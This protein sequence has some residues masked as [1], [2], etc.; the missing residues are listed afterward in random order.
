MHTRAMAIPGSRR[1]ASTASRPLRLRRIYMCVHT[2]TWLRPGT[3]SPSKKDQHHHHLR[4][5]LLPARRLA[6]SRARLAPSPRLAAVAAAADSRRGPDAAA[7]NE[8]PRAPSPRPEPCARPLPA[9]LRRPDEPAHEA[10]APAPRRRRRR[11]RRRRP[12]P[13]PSTPPVPHRAPRDVPSRRAPMS[14]DLLQRF[15]ESDVFNSNPFLSVS[16]LS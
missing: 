6:S 1:K 13:S 2:C 7:V 3:C 14:W 10:P 8:A 15:L 9:L 5:F 4:H 11:R 12:P 16:Y